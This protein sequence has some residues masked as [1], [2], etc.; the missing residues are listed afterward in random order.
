MLVLLNALHAGNVSG[1]GRYMAHL[2]RSLTALGDLDVAVVWPAGVA[3]NEPDNG[4]SYIELTATGAAQRIFFDQVG[5]RQVRSRLGADIVH[6]PASVGPLT[7]IPNTVLTIHDLSYLREP[8]WFPARRSLYYR[9]TILRSARLA[10]RIIADSQATADDLILLG[11]LPAAAIDVVHLGVDELFRPASDEVRAAVREKYTLPPKFFLFCGTLEPRKNIPHLITAWSSVADQ[12]DW[13]LV[14]AGRRGWGVG[15]IERAVAESPHADRIH[16]PGF[17]EQEDLPAVLSAAGAFVW[18]SLWEGFGLPPLEA[19]ACG[20]P[21]LTSST[22]SL[23]EVVGDAAVLVD[24][25]NVPAIAQ[26][27]IEL[28]QDETLRTDLR[29][30]GLARAAKFTWDKT[31][32]ET[33]ATYRKVM[34]A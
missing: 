16:P 31:A 17:I 18:P 27:M 26:G 10:A 34:Q 20:T 5:I 25:L 22:S 1:T 12:C 28:A 8:S 14:I 21:V 30:R 33:V 15:P 24:P 13:D 23:P 2:A 4:S 32:E 19:M 7:R 3:W 29:R 6:Y 9:K 11:G